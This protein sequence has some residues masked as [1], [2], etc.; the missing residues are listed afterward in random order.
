MTMASLAL[1]TGLG[2]GCSLFSAGSLTSS[3]ASKPFLPP[4]VKPQDAVSVEIMLADR[5]AGDPMFGTALWSNL[6]EI[7]ATSPANRNLLKKTG[8]QYG[9]SPSTPPF[10]VQ[11]ILS[12]DGKSATQRVQRLKY[13]FPS[14]GEHVV[15]T[16]PEVPLLECSL[17][18]G[19]KSLEKR[20]FKSAR[21]VFRIRVEKAEE[22]WARLDFT[23]EIHHG[24]IV[25]KRVPSEYGYLFQQGQEIE[26]LHDLKFSAELNLAELAVIGL[27]ESSESSL[28]HCFF[29]GASEGRLERVLMI[30]LADL[31]E[32]QPVRQLDH[33]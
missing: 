32:V 19:G 27:K 12:S 20:T 31:Y 15:E 13:G 24:P 11:A 16:W 6:N 3:P 8:F 7:S 18:A 22:G 2:T 5:A 30:R 21:C 25:T 26:A 33:A 10:A 23:P 17:P 28:G 29:R 9:L 1:P 4:I 14:G